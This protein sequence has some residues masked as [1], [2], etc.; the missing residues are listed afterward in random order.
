MIDCTI[1]VVLQLKHDGQDALCV[2]HLNFDAGRLFAR[3]FQPAQSSQP[4]R[5]KMIHLDERNLELETDAEV[6]QKIYK[7]RGYVVLP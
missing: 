4:Y 3:P 6:P 2:A 1:P 7:Y 5:P